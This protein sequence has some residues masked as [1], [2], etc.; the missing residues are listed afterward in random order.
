MREPAAAQRFAPLF[1]AALAG[2]I[3]LLL[4]GADQA[5]RVCGFLFFAIAAANPVG[6]R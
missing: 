2:G 3:Y 4:F 1:I 6:N 5:E